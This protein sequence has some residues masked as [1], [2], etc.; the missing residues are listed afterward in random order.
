M[1]LAKATDAE[2]APL[3]L[4]AGEPVEPFFRGVP[5]SPS[6]R[7]MLAGCSLT[8]LSRFSYAVPHA[9]Q[10]TDPGLSISA[11]RYYTLCRRFFI[12]ILFTDDR[13]AHIDGDV[14]AGNRPARARIATRLAGPTLAPSGGPATRCG[15]HCR[16]QPGS[17]HGKPADIGRQNHGC[18]S[19][20]GLR[21]QAPGGMENAPPKSGTDGSNP[22]SSASESSCTG[23]R[24]R[25]ML[26]RGAAFALHSGRDC[27]RSHRG[28]DAARLRAAGCYAPR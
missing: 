24:R 9:V 3:Y 19:R 11:I 20:A 17:A 15:Y 21:I 4:R 14:I 7:K 28:S 18:G 8:R 22:S 26:L 5:G 16:S 6:Q 27:G 10:S 25:P 23:P 12:L 1:L 2:E 13:G